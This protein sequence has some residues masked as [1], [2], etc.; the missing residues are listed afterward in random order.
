[1]IRSSDKDQ[2]A[3]IEGWDLAAAFGKE[4]LEYVDEL[5]FTTNVIRALN[6]I[7]SLKDRS[8]AENALKRTYQS[9]YSLIA[10]NPHLIQVFFLLSC[11][12]IEKEFLNLSE[13]A[14]KDKIKYIYE[15]DIEPYICKKGLEMV[16]N[17]FIPRNQAMAKA[18]LRHREMDRRVFIICGEAHLFDVNDSLQDA[19]LNKKALARKNVISLMKKDKYVILR[20]KIHFE[21]SLNAPQSR[22]KDP[23]QLYDLLDEL[24]TSVPKRSS[25]D[26]N[27]SFS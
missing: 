21:C 19:P 20:P 11:S 24:R 1:M 4:Y 23:G 13:D 14:R 6:E 9:C 5:L 3:M 10:K 12:L 7:S 8:I 18:I 15:K 2:R 16:D 27:F 25:L 22:E 26:E 17:D